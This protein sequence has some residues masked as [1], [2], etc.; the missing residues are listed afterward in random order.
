MANL[1]AI[2][3]KLKPEIESLL[4]DGIETV[5]RLSGG[6]SADALALRTSRGQYYFLKLGRR[7]PNDLFDSEARGLK[8]IAAT[9]TIMT[10]TIVASTADFLLL[11][12]I[13]AAVPKADY[14]TTFARQLAAL[15]NHTAERFGFQQDNYCGATPQHNRWQENGHRFFAEQ[16]LLYQA[17]RAVDKGLLTATEVR[18][19]EQLCLR[20]PEL[21][22][23]QP[24]SLIHGDLWCGN[25]ICNNRGQPV[26]F[27]PACHYGWAEAELAMTR[28][29]GGFGEGFYAAYQELRPQVR[30]WQQR[31]ELYNLYHLLNHLNLFGMSYYPRVCSI[32]ECYR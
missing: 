31:C 30:G 27:D 3:A 19:I 26:L 25:Q 1:M 12:W 10:P 9:H 29:F 7:L 22:P 4:G 24:A 6:D 20:L 18:A 11:D 21:I 17:Q 28:L 32:I 15:H 14:W 8:A 13:V 5:R 23:A 2:P 16:R